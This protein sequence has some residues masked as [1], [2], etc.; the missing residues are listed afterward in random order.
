MIR[1][2][3]KKNNRK[4][5]F[6]EYDSE[7]NERISNKVI[8]KKIGYIPNNYLAD[9]LA[10]S[11]IDDI[12]E[13]FTSGEGIFIPNINIEPRKNSPTYKYLIHK[14][15]STKD[16]KVYI[17]EELRKK[18]LDYDKMMKRTEEDTNV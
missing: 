9:S 3:A 11:Y 17:N 15:S 12:F 7:F 10:K 6:V 16:K 18:I 8:S 14:I 1:I 4:I 13:K 2:Y 5:R